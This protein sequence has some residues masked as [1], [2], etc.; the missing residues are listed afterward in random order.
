M[1]KVLELINRILKI[2]RG[3]RVFL[4]SDFTDSMLWKDIDLWAELYTSL[5]DKKSKDIKKQKS[6]NILG[7]F[8]NVQKLIGT[9]KEEDKIEI[10]I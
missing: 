7:I 9:A 1:E 2:E 8:N 4:Y 3:Q 10:V 6:S 5:C